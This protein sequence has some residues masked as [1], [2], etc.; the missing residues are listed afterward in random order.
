[1][2]D[3]S[4]GAALSGGQDAAHLRVFGAANREKLLSEYFAHVAEFC[5]AEAWRHIYRLLMWID[6]TTGLAHCYESDKCQPGEP[7]YARSLAFHGW[8]STQLAVPPSG[9]VEE[10]DWLF[11]K[12]IANLAAIA[13][14]S[15]IPEKGQQQRKP[16]EG[17]D[18]PEPGHDP[19][20]AETILETLEGYLGSQPS[21]ETLREL[22]ERVR[23]YM[24]SENKRKNLVGEGFEDALAA[25]VRRIPEIRDHYD[26]KARSLLHLLPGFQAPPEGTKPRKVDLALV[27]QSDQHRILITAKWSI[28]S[29]REEQFGP[30]FADY[31]KYEFANKDFD[32]VLITNEFD[33]ARLVRACDRRRENAAL[34][35]D[36]VHVNPQGLATAYTAL[37]VRGHTNYPVAL[38]RIATGRLS[39]LEAWLN[40]LAGQV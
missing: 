33:P 1:M 29:D 26:I 30:D 24:S 35:T 37:P 32:Y 25:V 9:L 40:K 18:F 6:R 34:F 39:S 2:T 7:W 11:R 17:Q 3:S 4:K 27:R 31:A 36:V 20:L 10:V 15:G 16:Y 12:V 14:A 5:P 19:G 13:T 21:Q 8:V 28:R 22:V 23:A 38:E